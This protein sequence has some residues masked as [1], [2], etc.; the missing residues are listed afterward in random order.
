M[1]VVIYSC[2]FPLAVS[3]S[4]ISVV[5]SKF[6]DGDGNQFF[7]KGT[8]LHISYPTSENISLRAIFSSG[9]D[10]WGTGVVYQPGGTG[11]SYDPLSAEAQCTQDVGSRTTVYGQD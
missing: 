8:S 1:Q 7:I 3:L 9:A 11:I 6:Y 10:S 4:T 5:G 2:L